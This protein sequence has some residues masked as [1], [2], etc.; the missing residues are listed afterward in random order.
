MMHD[1]QRETV[2][3]LDK[4]RKQLRLHLTGDVEQAKYD[5]HPRTLSR[6]WIDLKRIQIRSAADNGR[7]KLA[8]NAPLI[9]L[10]SVA[11]LLFAARKPISDA[12]NQLRT[13]ARQSEDEMT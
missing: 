9:G 3:Q 2:A 8:K 5:L 6:R 12:I 10:A 13:K 4:R 11:I 1:D 7:Q